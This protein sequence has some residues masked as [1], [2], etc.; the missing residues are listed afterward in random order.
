[1][2]LMNAKGTRDFPP[3]EKIVRQ[4]VL[5]I[6]R[7]VFES[8]GYSPLETPIIER[9]DILTSKYAGGA[10]ILKETFTF[11]DQGKRDLGLRYDLTVPF[12]RFVGM[13]PTMKM[14]FKRYQIGRVFRDGP[15]KLGRYR[16]FWQCDVDIVGTKNMLADAEIVMVT[17]DVFKKLGLDVVIEVNNR[18]L[19]DGLLESLKIPENKRMD[20]ILAI[21]KIKKV[22]LEEIEKELASKGVEKKKVDEMLKIFKTSGSNKEKIAKLK[23]IVKTP[24]GIEGLNEIEECLSYIK[25]KNVEFSISLCRGLAYYT[26]TVF[27]GFLK[28]GSFKS[29][30]CGGGRYDKMIGD[31]LGSGEYPALGISFGIEPIT[32]VL[33]MKNKCD[34]KKTVTELFILPIGT[35]KECIKIASQLRKEGVKVD[36]D[37]MGRG[38]SKNLNYANSLGIPYVAFVGSNELKKKKIKLK[39]M[40]SGKEELISVKDVVKK[41]EK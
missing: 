20:V 9:L 39:D 19:L 24:K 29:S 16:E 10:E 34:V 22:S 21:D 35:T 17:Q 14:P 31:Y 32:E 12:S 6:F 1:M 26:G 33:K 3:E 37:V 4:N 23:K 30:L 5:D 41:I 27:E 28:D 7:Q 18:K 8:F 11:K 13:N 38:I 2:Q 40:K 36:M 25:G 15:I